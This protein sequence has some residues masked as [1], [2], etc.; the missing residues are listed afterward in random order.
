MSSM[1]HEQT[2]GRVFFDVCFQ[3]DSGLER[4]IPYKSCRRRRSWA[5]GR[6]NCLRFASA[7]FRPSGVLGPVLSPP[8]ILHRP[9]LGRSRFLSHTAGA[10]QG[11]PGRVR[12]LQCGLNRFGVIHSTIC[13]RDQRGSQAKHLWHRNGSNLLTFGRIR[14]IENGKELRQPGL[15]IRV[16]V[17]RFRPWAPVLGFVPLRDPP[18]RNSVDIVV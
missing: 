9:F 6:R 16:S 5:R 3:V 8:C 2:L 17:V 11:R 10:L 18:R 7:R 14:P 1:G 12:A 15:K 13:Q 4:Q